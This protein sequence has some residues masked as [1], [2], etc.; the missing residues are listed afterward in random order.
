MSTRMKAVIINSYGNNDVLDCIDAERPTPLAGEVLVHVH[1]AGVNPVDWKIRGGAGQ[2]MGMT[3]PI[4]LGGEIA[5]T[6]VELGE[7]VEAL[8]EGDEVYGIIPAGGFAE[9]VAVK[10]L[11]LALKPVSLDFIQAAAVP[12]GA[13]TA[14][15]AIFDAAHLVANQSLF[16]TNGSGSV[17]SMAVQLAKARGSHVTAMASGGNEDYVRSL[18]ADDFIDYTQNRFEHVAQGMDV[19]FDTVGGE[20]F[21]RS[22]GTVKKDGT[23]VT[24][25]A[26][27]TDADRQHGFKVERV[28][29]KPNAQQ[30]AYVRELVETGKLKAR[31]GKVLPLKDIAE[32]LELSEHGRNPG[33]IILQI[34][35][36]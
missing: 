27:P 4:H 24:V 5:G 13:L 15:Q 31:V 10:A 21:Q 12:L 3:L 14:W 1:A 19:V 34:A 2:R 36:S 28:Q 26:F 6:V 32:A 22:F 20:T 16:V 11:D 23:L 35:G 30:L 18:G 8:H 29:C 9:Y 33:K 17:G 7:G 25:V